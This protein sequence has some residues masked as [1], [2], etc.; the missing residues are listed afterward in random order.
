MESSLSTVA[1]MSLREV[2][3]YENWSSMELTPMTGFDIS[4]TALS[5]MHQGYCLCSISEPGC[6]NIQQCHVVSVF[7]VTQKDTLNMRKPHDFE[8]KEG[9]DFVQT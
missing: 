8:W 9:T 5:I 1:F 2:V 6:C 3:V 7:L 4:Y